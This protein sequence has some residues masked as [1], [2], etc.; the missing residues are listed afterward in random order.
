MDVKDLF[1]EHERI[2]IDSDEK[3]DLYL[4]SHQERFHRLLFWANLAI[5]FNFIMVM[6]RLVNVYKGNVPAEIL[7]LKF[8]FAVIFGAYA[9]FLIVQWKA[10]ISLGPVDGSRLR[11]LLHYKI[12]IMDKQAKII[13]G[14]LI[15]YTLTL[16]GAYLFY[17]SSRL[18]DPK[19]VWKTSST[20]SVVMFGMGIYLLKQ[21]IAKRR[22]LKV[23]LTTLKDDE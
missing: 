9:G 8:I 7:P 14:Y 1:D 23:A 16:F 18:A 21:W 22:N 10:E 17:L 15:G 4:D 11:C 12:G 20:V 3:L 13:A 2:K 6:S 5:L 19:L